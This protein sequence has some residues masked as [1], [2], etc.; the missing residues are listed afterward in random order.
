[1]ANFSKLPVENELAQL[2]LR[3]FFH[4]QLNIIEAEGLFYDDFVLD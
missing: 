1:M 4:N 3:D 2:V